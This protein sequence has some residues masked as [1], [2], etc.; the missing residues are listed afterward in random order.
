M[1]RSRPSRPLPSRKGW[2]VSNWAWA[3][4]MRMSKGRSSSACRKCSRSPREFS[5][6]SGGGG[7]NAA[8]RM[9]APVRADPVLR[10]PHLSGS[11]IRSPDALKQL[12][13][14]VPHETDGDRQ[15]FQQEQSKL[16][17]ADVV[18][19]LSGVDRSGRGKELPLDGEHVLQR[20]L[21]SFYLTGKQRLLADVHVDKD[22]GVGQREVRA[23]QA[24]QGQVGLRQHCS[25]GP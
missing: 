6:T 19:H 18:D 15:G 16:H 10:G 5:A 20:A 23:V 14:D 9:V 24:A 7:T 3:R 11:E 2:M 25:G 13:V 1:I 8:S 4:P 22:V 17:C 21:R 12:P